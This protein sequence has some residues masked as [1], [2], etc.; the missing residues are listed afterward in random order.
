MIRNLYFLDDDLNNDCLP[1]Y[2]AVERLE[3]A[4]KHIQ[5]REDYLKE[6]FKNNEL[7]QVY[8]YFVSNEK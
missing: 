4:L 2:M 8:K 1:F 5:E 6:N 7:Y 3:L